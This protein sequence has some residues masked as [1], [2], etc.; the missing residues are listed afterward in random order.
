MPIFGN[1]CKIKQ[2][3][4][5]IAVFNQ[6]GGVGKTTT[7]VNLGAYLTTF[8]KK[9]LI[10]DF[11]PQANASSALGLKPLELN[12]SIYHGF[13]NLI[14]ENLIN[15]SEIKNLDFIHSAPHLA[16]ALVELVNLDNREFYLRKFLH[17][18]R[19]L[20]DYIL[21]DLPPALSLLTINGLVAADEVIVPVQT[22]Y[23]SLEGL[24]QALEVL[25]LVRKNLRHN[26]VITGIFMTMFGYNPLSKEIEKNLKDNLGDKV[27]KTKIPRDLALAEAPSFSKTILS[28]KPSSKGAKQYR[29]LAEEIIESEIKLDKNFGNFII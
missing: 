8:S 7:A 10:V 19:H 6:K 9:T 11:D 15:A 28:Y 18:F 29:K 23:Y 1:F 21:I 22:E 13:L 16:G 17:K 26:I 5:V 27:L 3:A 14:D 4:R 20:Y 25:D 24:T 2:M 12:K